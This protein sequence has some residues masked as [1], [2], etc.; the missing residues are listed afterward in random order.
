MSSKSYVSITQKK[1]CWCVMFEC[2][3]SETRHFPGPKLWSE[4]NLAAAFIACN[5]D[6]VE[7]ILSM[8]EYSCCRKKIIPPDNPPKNRGLF[9]AA[10][11][12]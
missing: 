10:S 12:F 2:A 7:Y 8:N 1:L 4:E 6:A 3:V 11:V 5:V 9:F